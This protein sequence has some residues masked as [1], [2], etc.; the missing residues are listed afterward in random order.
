[1]RPGHALPLLPWSEPQSKARW[2][3]SMTGRRPALKEISRSRSEPAIRVERADAAGLSGKPVVFC[4]KNSAIRTN[5]GRHA[6]SLAMCVSMGQRRGIS[7]SPS[8]RKAPCV[9]SS[10]SRRSS[11]TR[12]ATTWS[13]ATRSSSRRWLRFCV[14]IA[15]SSSSRRPRQQPNK[16]DAV[17]H[18]V[19]REARNSG[20]R[21]HGA[22][23]ATRA[24]RARDLRTRSRIQAPWHCQFAGRY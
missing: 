20:D 19:R 7:A 8:W 2:R 14:S 16:S 11:R 1:M 13:A 5:C 9:R 24:R 21:Q 3:R 6:F 17:D 18:F 10:T 12:S 15:R 23:P 4:P 22:G